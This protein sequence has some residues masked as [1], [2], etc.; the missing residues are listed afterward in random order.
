MADLVCCNPGR[1]VI[2]YVK[3][4]ERVGVGS[5]KVG[6]ELMSGR[7]RLETSWCWVVEGWKRVDVGSSK[8]GNELM[9]GRRR[10]ETS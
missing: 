4:S 7:R 2:R 8:V 3:S 10:L 9:L 5:S 1:A 6:N